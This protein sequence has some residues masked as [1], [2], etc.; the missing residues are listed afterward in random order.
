M[1]AETEGWPVTMQGL[2]SDA[3][4]HPS[5]GKSPLTRRGGG[6]QL[7]TTTADAQPGA[8]KGNKLESASNCDDFAA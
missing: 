5:K 3:K 4:T 6:L 2:A 8:S 1:T 7:I